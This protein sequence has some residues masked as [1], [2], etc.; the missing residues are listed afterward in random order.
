[1]NKAIYGLK[2]A[3]K[4]WNRTFTKW[5]VE[6]AGFEQS[7]VD[8]CIFFHHDKKVVLGVYVDDM[9]LGA[10]R[11]HE[12]DQVKSKLQQ[13]FEMRTMGMPTF[14]LGM[15]ITYDIER[16]LITLNQKTYIEALKQKFVAE[17]K[18]P[19]SLPMN[20]GCKLVKDEL[21]SDQTSE[22]YSS[23]VGALLFLSVCT[24]PD[25]SFAVNCLA[26]FMSSPSS[27]HWEALMELMSYVTQSSNI[28]ISI[29]DIGSELVL[30]GYAD[31][32]WAND[33]NDRKSISGG[34]LFWGGSI[35][36]WYSRKQ[37]MVSTSTAEAETHAMMEM[38]HTMQTGRRLATE[39]NLFGRT[40]G[41]L[42]ACILVDNQPA[43]DAVLGGRGRTKHYEV[44]VKYIAQCID[45]GLF[46]LQKVHTDLNI[47]DGFTKPL[48]RT[49]FQKFLS[50]TCDWYKSNPMGTNQI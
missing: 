22:P 15:N 8:E 49:K 27:K 19:R 29:G 14:F 44:K 46:D 11:Q 28:G 21:L 23:L 45:A 47:A 6:D 40:E 25:I 12:M 50:E 18:N 32:D 39:F 10:Q 37:S 24:R 42:Q 34:V 43:I 36:H 20:P 13:K 4:A 17:F 7:E 1:L 38:C 16:G 5:A 2:R 35:V 41:Q 30:T 9:L 33:L 48:G 3:P 31:S 26:K